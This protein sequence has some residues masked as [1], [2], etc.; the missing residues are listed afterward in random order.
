MKTI[1]IAFFA[2]A[3]LLLTAN[4]GMAITPEKQ[5]IEKEK[6]M[7]LNKIRKSVTK[8]DFGDFIEVGRTEQ[9]VLR[10]TVNENNLVVVS[11]VIGF[12]EEL[13]QAVRNAMDHKLISA[14]SDLVGEEL[15]LLFKFEMHK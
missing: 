10:C 13:K 14:S 12:D 5:K 4:L 9:I 1:K 11:K 3:C 8:I 2:L 15:A 7:L 6:S